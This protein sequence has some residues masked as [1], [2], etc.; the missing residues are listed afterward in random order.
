MK[1][2]KRMKNTEKFNAYLKEYREKNKSNY[3]YTIW[4]KE[5]Y[6][7]RVGSCCNIK[8]RIAY[9]ISTNL[10]PADELAGVSY[11]EVK[12]REYAYALEYELMDLY[13]PIYN[14][15][16][17]KKRDINLDIDSLKNADI[18]YIYF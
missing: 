14:K 3:V 12:D 10:L 13:K 15:N 6:P 2:M 5:G 17:V 4:N 1:G 8:N 7:I 16:D 11:L 9:Y 18:K